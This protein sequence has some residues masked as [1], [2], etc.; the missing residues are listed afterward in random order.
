MTSDD[1][2]RETYWT[3]RD[4]ETQPLDFDPPFEVLEPATLTS[5]LVFSSPHSGAVY[6]RRFLD[7]AR[8]DAN[9]LRRSEDVAVDELF[10]GAVRLG[11]PLLRA[12]FP[13]AF[14]DVNREPYELDPK[15]FEG[16]LPV[17]SNT[18]S[19]RVAAGLGTIARLV[20][21]SQEIYSARLPVEEAMRRI[22]QLYKPYHRALRAL[23]ERA[24]RTFGLAVLVDC[25]SMPSS[26]QTVGQPLART[27][28]NRP[29]AARP[30]FVLGDRFGT[31]C[32]SDLMTTVEQAL[33][34]MGYRVQ[35]NKPYA[36]GFITEHY[37]K[38][39]SHFHA[40][41]IEVSRGLYMN[42]KSF[43]KIARFSYIA[44]D[45]TKMV[46]LLMARLADRR[47]QETS[48]AAE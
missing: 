18:R 3:A 5:P 10:Q 36:G 6:P 8:L 40:L 38:P 26:I 12:H 41:Q 22:D 35:R 46:A 9:T 44:D 27:A 16:K 32:A 2:A 30:D 45:L 34:E 43:E 37:G 39:V 24:E 47:G 17:F 20:G 13:R 33:R 19:L 42:E 48:Q 15:M 14:L 11:A 21:E 1:S 28:S 4:R 25:H 23:L 29:D 7:L 31:S